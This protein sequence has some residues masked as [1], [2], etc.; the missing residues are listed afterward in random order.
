MAIRGTKKEKYKIRGEVDFVKSNILQSLQ[1]AGFKN[2]ECND[3]VN[4]IKASYNSFI[5]VGYIVITLYEEKEYVCVEAEA[6]A[7]V[8]NIFA[9]ISSPTQK[10]LN[11]F[12]EY[13]KYR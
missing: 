11:K 10:I 9:L 12:K 6:T 1:L 7:N 8:D 5:V 3:F 13:L 4:Q 2:I